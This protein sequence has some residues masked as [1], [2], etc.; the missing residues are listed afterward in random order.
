MKALPITNQN[1]I[2]LK[3]GRSL[4]YT[5]YG[6]PLG[7]PI[8]ALHGTP[9]SRIWF[10]DDDPVS[11]KL[12]IKLITI[13][14]PGYS[15]STPQPKRKI[16]DFNSDIDELIREL[17]V[18]RFSIFGVSGGGAFAL[19]YASSRNPKLHKTA[20]VASVYEFKNGK[21]PKDMCRPNR[22][23]FFLANYMPWI[24]RYTYK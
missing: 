22:M 4:G 1:F 17:K 11:T 16:A 13:D 9:G 19:A 6:D 3:D 20:L 8:I 14:R 24:L 21:V 12:G 18:E 2:T 5:I 10:K 7:F 23:G 15:I